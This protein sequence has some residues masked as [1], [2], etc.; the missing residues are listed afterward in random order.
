M[1]GSTVTTLPGEHVLR[2]GTQRRRL[3]WIS[4]PT[5]WPSPWPNA[6]AEPARRDRDARDGVDS[7]PWHPAR[8]RRARQLAPRGRRRVRL[9]QLGRQLAGRER[10]RAVGAVAVDPHP[11][12]TMTSRSCLD[13]AVA[14]VGMRRRA[15]RAGRHDGVRRRAPAPPRG[16]RSRSTRRAPA[17]CGRRTAPRRARVGLVR[18]RGRPPDRGD[19]ARLLHARSASTTRRGT[20]SSPPPARASHPANVTSAPR[21]RPCRRQNGRERPN[22]SRASRRARRPRR[23]PPRQVRKSV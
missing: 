5:P 2:L 20:R 15:V 21:S 7:R 14:R 13:D 11:A 23:P 6:V 8:R 17:R 3:S 9:A 22:T 1:P 16:T 12:S 19:L 18:D 10:A 4:R